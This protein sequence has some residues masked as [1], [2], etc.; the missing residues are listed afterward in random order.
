[1]LNDKGKTLTEQKR[2]TTI[3]VRCWGDVHIVI[4]LKSENICDDTY[5]I[6]ICD[7]QNATIASS[8]VGCEQIRKAPE[9]ALVVIL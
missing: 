1:M 7:G 2:R 8:Q 4:I 3:Q 5:L 9:S 6:C